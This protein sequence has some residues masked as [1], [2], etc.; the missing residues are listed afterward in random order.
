VLEWLVLSVVTGAIAGVGFVLLPHGGHWLRV[1]PGA[2]GF[3][4]GVRLMNLVVWIYV[5][6][7]IERAGDLYGSLGL[8]IAILLYLY[9]LARLFVGAQFVNATLSG[10]VDE[11]IDREALASSAA[12]FG[13]AEQALRRVRGEADRSTPPGTPGSE[14]PSVDSTG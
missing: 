6:H 4:V 13:A 11:P 10:V 12:M 5:W 3:A 14:D 9:L 7:R 1:L 8:S 2:V